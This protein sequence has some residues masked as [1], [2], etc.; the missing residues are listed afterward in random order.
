MMIYQGKQIRVRTP[1]FIGMEFYA[2]KCAEKAYHHEL[3]DVRAF[4]KKRN[5]KYEPDF[6]KILIDPEMAIVITCPFG[7]V[8]WVNGGFQRMSGYTPDEIIGKSPGMLQGKETREETKER[9][10]HKIMSRQPFT[11]EIV[12]YRKSG[13]PYVC[14]LDVT[15]MFNETED[16]VN[17]IALEREVAMV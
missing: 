15:P 2:P 9:I 1:L 5:W 10:K 3:G 4:A 16:L 14:Q 8:E 11:D 7:L 6:D 12:N 17:Y 13:E